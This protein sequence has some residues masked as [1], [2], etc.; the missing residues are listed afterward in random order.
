MYEPARTPSPNLAF[1]WPAIAAASASD[2]AAAFARHFTNLAVGDE[3]SSVAAPQ[4][5]TPNRIALDLMTVQLRDFS[6]EATGFPT[7]ICAPFALH[8]AVM[9]DLT[10]GHS[11]VAALRDASLTRLFVTDWHSATA[12]MRFLSIDSY[13]AD[14]N[15]LI[16]TIGPPVDLI[17]LCQGGWMA[18][19][20]AARFPEKIRKVVLAA[21]PIDIA[22]APS[23]ISALAESNPL[24][25]FHEL[26]RLGDGLVPGQKVLKFWGPQSIA[27]EDVRQLLQ[28]DEPVGSSA[29]ADL[30]AMY[31][32]WYAW[33]VDLPGIFFIETVERLYK[34]NEIAGGSFT[35]L[36]QKVDLK[37]ITT[38]L[39]ML[40]AR[41]DELVAPAQL[42]AAEN[43]V[44]TSPDDVCKATAPCG[45][46]GLFMGKSILRDVWPDVARWLAGS[47]HSNRTGLPAREIVNPTH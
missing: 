12:E 1:L 30:E 28:S 19:I 44:G 32:A 34:R 35:A 37:A 16:D 10:A 11:L 40:A 47:P 2:M 22:A 38:P 29:F 14:L 31:R 43:L 4:W 18:L 27:S 5:T 6:T 13:L 3:V 46:L 45:H 21:A 23:A 26:V 8:G 36:G 42:F 41:D 9:C 33:T 17:G 39:F 25:V 24:A 15:V 20:Y 7:L